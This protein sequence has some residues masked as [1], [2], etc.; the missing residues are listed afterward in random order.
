MPNWPVNPQDKEKW[1]GNSGATVH[2]TNDNTGMFNIRKCDF[3]ITVG[4]QE[5][6]KCTMMGDIN[7]RLWRL[8]YLR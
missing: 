1:I 2:I 4:N 3:D 6:T 7:L 8:L 5:T